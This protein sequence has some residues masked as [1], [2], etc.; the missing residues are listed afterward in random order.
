M[1]ENMRKNGMIT[2]TNSLSLVKNIHKENRAFI[3]GSG[4]S[5]NIFDFNKINKEDIIFACNQSITALKRCNYF[6]MTDGA[7]P[8]ANF[9]DYGR[10]I[11]DKIAFCSGTSFIKLPAVIEQYEKIKEK[12]YFFNRRYNQPQNMN[13]NIEDDSLIV[14]TDVVHVTSHLAH[15]MGCNPLI[16]VG[17]D[18][19]YKKGQKY[20]S[21]T[22]FKKDI[23]WSRAEQRPGMW[24]ISKNPSGEGDKNLNDSYSTWISIKNA[25]KNVIFLNTNPCGKLSN[26]FDLFI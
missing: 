12:S 3:F 15:I 1:E 10:E 13:F 8:E 23:I 20:C 22:E 16:L 6:C 14:G 26:L 21:N 7:I 24:P 18:L 11:S 9:F 17:V 25:N 19:N 2:N 5:V 4:Y